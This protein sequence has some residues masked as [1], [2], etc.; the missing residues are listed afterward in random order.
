[1]AIVQTLHTASQFADAFKQSARAA[2]FSYEALEAIYDYLEE[3]SDSCGE[4]IEFDVV[5][6]CCEFAESSLSDIAES[7]NIKLEGLEGED[8]IEAV[9]SYLEEHTMIVDMLNDEAIVFVQF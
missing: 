9:V 6:I 7:Y 5:A 8:R 3:L 4:P 2:Q 1:M